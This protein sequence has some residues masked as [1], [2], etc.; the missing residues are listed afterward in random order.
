MVASALKVPRP[1]ENAKKRSMYAGV[2][3]NLPIA[4]QNGALCSPA[5]TLGGML[6]LLLNRNN[7]NTATT[8]TIIASVNI[9]RVISGLLLLE[10]NREGSTKPIATP[11]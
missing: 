10:T 6:G 2:R 3:I 11:I 1:I 9:K 4:L 7:T 5:L 8:D